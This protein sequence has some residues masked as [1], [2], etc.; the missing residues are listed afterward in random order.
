MR[1]T[2]FG[3]V[4]TGKTPPT[5]QREFFDGEYPFIT[6][7]DLEYDS[8]YVTQTET[9]V[10]NDAK[11]RFP[12]QFIPAGAITYTCIASVGKIGIA[13]RESL[14]NQ[15]INSLI[16]NEHH[17]G[18]FL[19]YLL[20]NET[21]QIQGLCSG[22]ATP[23]INKSDFEKIELDVP[24][25]LAVERTIGMI[26][27]AYDD[28]IENNRRRMALLEDAAQ[29]LYN[30]WF[31]RLHFPGHEHTRITDGVPDGWERKTLGDLCAEVRK[32]VKPDA[33]DPDTPYIGLEHMPRRS[34]S[35]SEWGTAEQVVSSK[36]RFC[37]GEI[38]FGKIRPYFHKVGV[39]F[40]D[41]VASSDAIVIRPLDLKVHGLVLMAVSSDP[42]VAVTAQ[43]MREGSKMPRADWKQMRE[44]PV[45]LPPDGLLGS[46]ESQI[47]SIVE[48]LKT[49]SFANHKLR[50]ARDLL[51]PRLMSGEIAV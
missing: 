10:T 42:F 17:D 5:K 35:L 29:Q 12:N 28:L 2:D 43:T 4:V 11:T 19:Y 51:L 26:L 50:A 37:E 9:S 40:V 41:G 24:S 45:P 6:P 3:R 13:E 1:I 38:L 47:Q 23:I 48:Q 7:S 15:Q 49:L 44:Y 18:K 36:H 22:V 21:K 46:F 27:S 33:L 16:P 34:I 39:V 32:S 14:T 8:Y 20:R 25:E 31:V 30:E